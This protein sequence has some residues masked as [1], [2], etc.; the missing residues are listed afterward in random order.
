MVKVREAKYLGVTLTEDRISESTQ[1]D[2]SGYINPS[3][4]HDGGMECT[5]RRGLRKKGERSQEGGRYVLWTN[6]G[7][8]REKQHR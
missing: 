3:S 4:S 5:W 2:L 8:S 1:Q 6:P 7:E